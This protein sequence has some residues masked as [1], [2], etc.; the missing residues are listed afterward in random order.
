MIS[1]QRNLHFQREKQKVNSQLS[2]RTYLNSVFDEKEIT[3]FKVYRPITKRVSKE[4]RYAD[5]TEENTLHP[6]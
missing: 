5:Y 6:V 2:K 1:R 3:G 4:M